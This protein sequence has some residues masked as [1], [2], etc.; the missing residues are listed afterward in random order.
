MTSQELLGHLKKNPFVLA[1]MAG[2]TDS[3]FR[4]FMREM[5]AGIVISELVSAQGLKYNSQK[6]KDLMRFD[7][8]ERPVGIQL[9]GE[10]GD[11]IGEAAKYVQD[12]G[13]DFVDLN[14][15]CPVNKVVK[16][17]AGAAATRDLISFRNLL[18]KVRAAI[19]LP[20]TIK[21]RTGWDE[22][23]RNALDVVRVAHDEGV[24]WVAIHGRTRTQGYS[25]LSDWDF[26]RYVKS[27]AP[28]P[29]I[30]N[31]DILTAA[32]AR[33][34]LS[35]SGCDGVMIGRGCLKDPRIF[36]AANGLDT[37]DESVG[38]LIGR[39]GGYLLD[40]ATGNYP[41]I[42]LRKFAMWYSYGLP[43]ASVFRR[44]L[45]SENDIDRLKSLIESYFLRVQNCIKVVPGR[46]DFLM[47]GHG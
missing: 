27:E 42:Q 28:L 10:C 4:R 5:G 35:E 1:P 6:T 16:K 24:T 19:E 30:G 40:G 33:S 17:G 23:S 8:R 18:R 29:V 2:I 11:I 15:G 9:F 3:P 31:G 43:E 13:A 32:M 34:R 47:G 12:Q 46:D 37:S 26:I 36:Q 45:F 44:E 7:E 38:D 39:L 41:K 25:G 20:L 22:E 21:I 14:F